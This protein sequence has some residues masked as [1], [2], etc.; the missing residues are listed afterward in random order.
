MIEKNETGCDNEKKK[1]E[2]RDE[3]DDDGGDVEDEDYGKRG[4]RR[5][6]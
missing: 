6:R 2:R 1:I 5:G 3:D 4:L